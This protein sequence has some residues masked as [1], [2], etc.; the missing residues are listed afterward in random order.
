VN[1]K[2]VYAAMT[3]TVVAAAV[4]LSPVSAP[5]AGACGPH[6]LHIDACPGDTH[7]TGVAQNQTIDCGDGTLFINGSD[8]FITALGSCHAITLQGSGNTVVADNVVNDI[9]VFG[10]GQTVL[11][12]N[13]TPAVIDRGREL[14]MINRIDRVP[15]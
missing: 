1:S 4:S 3:F 8:N 5:V 12:K 14:G 13:G 9:T 7:I 6:G 11:Y 2:A 10:F 15:A